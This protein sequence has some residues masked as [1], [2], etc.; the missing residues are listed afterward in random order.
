MPGLIEPHCTDSG[1][2]RSST[3]TG[4][5]STAVLSTGADLS[6]SFVGPVDSDG[7]NPDDVNG[8]QSFDSIG[9]RADFDNEFRS[10]GMSGLN[11]P[12]DVTTLGHCA[13]GQVCAIWDWRLRATDNAL[14]NVNGTFANG[15]PCPASV[16]G[17]QAMTDR[18]T[19]PNT[20]LTH[21]LEVMLDEMG[22]DD[23]LCES[24]EAC[25]YSPNFGS[26][27]GEGDY[28]TQ[29]CTFADGTVSG[30]TLYAYPTNGA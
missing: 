24:G 4:Q 16:H 25:I 9:N 19:V 11:F 30:V 10:W 14:R 21:A 22:D 5:S 8:T 13:S 28:T 27:Q 23:G 12:N 26:Y 3:D 2:A 17:D 15:A 7:T 1:A 20:F 6:L 18:S 29:T